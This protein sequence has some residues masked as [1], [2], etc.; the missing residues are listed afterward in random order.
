MNYQDILFEQDGETAW[1]SINREDKGNAFRMETVRE[2]IDAFEHA[3]RDADCRTVVLTGVGSRFFC[4]GGDHDAAHES[5]D[6]RIHYGTMF[7]VA[8]LYDLIDK[9]P[10]PVIAM[11]NGY[12]VGGGNVLAMMC[13]LTIAS[14]T[15]VFRQVGPMM[16]SFDAGFGTWYL[17]EAIGRKRAKEMWYLGRKYSAEQAYAM[18]LV[19]EV[20]EPEKLRER[21]AEICRELAARGP[22][23][24]AALK[25]AFHARHAGAPGLSRVTVDLLVNQYYHTEESRELGRAFGEKR[26]PDKSKFYR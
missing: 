11:V 4:I 3:R 2:M 17:E 18:G 10:K 26:E 14:R 1:I 9:I 23:A 7:P 25:A 21:V 20:V 5:A 12:A 6:D 8:D 22:M 24:I 16:G 13:D 15:A 19:N